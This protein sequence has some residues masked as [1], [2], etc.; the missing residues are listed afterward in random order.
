[1]KKTH[2][3]IVA[4]LF[5]ALAI[6]GCA[7]APEHSSLQHDNLPGL[8]PIRD[9]FI[10]IDSQLGYRLSPDG[11]KIGWMAVKK[12]RVTIFF[13]TIGESDVKVINTHSP[14]SI[15]G[16]HWAQDSQRMLYHQDRE[17]NENSHVYLVDT[18]HPERKPV[19]LTPFDETKAR[20][21]KILRTDP[22]NVL[23]E[24]NQ[25]DK[26]VYD[27]YCVNLNTLELTQ[28]AKNPG[29]VFSWITDDNGNLRARMRKTAQED[30]I[31]EVLNPSEKS[32]EKIIM[33]AMEDW[34]NYLSFTKDNKSMWL[35]SNRNRDRMGLVH[36]DLES[37]K[38]IL[39]YE[40]P[41]VDLGPVIISYLTKKPI[42]AISYPDYPKFHFFD[43]ESKKDFMIF[44]KSGPVGLRLMSTDNSERLVTLSV[45]TDKTVEYY[46]FKRDTKEKALLSRHP[47]SSYEEALSTVQPISFNSRDG[48]TIH[49]YLTIPKGSS[50]QNL[51][52][53]VLVHGGPWYRDYWGYK[54]RVQFLANRGYAV[55]Q[56]NYRGSTGYGRVFREAAVGEFAGKMHTDLIDGVQWAIR[57]GIADPQKIGVYGHSYGGYATLV[58]L[59]FTPET[60]ACGVDAVGPS[61]LV[62]LLE[63]VPKYWKHWM[64]YWY[65]YVGTPKNPEDRREM[66]EKSP[67]FRVSG[68]KRPL[69]I[70]QGGNDPRVK[71]KES[72][73][74]VSAMR[75][76][77]KEVEYLLFSDEGHSFTHWKN[78]LVFYRKVEDFLAKHLGGR[79]AGFDLYELAL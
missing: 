18:R 22:E 32:W 40:D 47:I 30:R 13:K 4:L 31:L 60:F 34:V 61:N 15:F 54:D 51:P 45:Y 55:L 41:K 49:G 62:T 59:T 39:I 6:V 3:I 48:L 36:F 1:M 23:I 67:L 70:A 7:T 56:I 9:L 72:D 76:A 77:G 79:S 33:W 57:K 73:Q 10:N 12:R 16:F 2:S 37:G 25:R 28:I 69:L 24:H 38:E 78:R 27:L 64:G 50:G 46:L 19:D 14:R 63:S 53:V 75:E 68:I 5:I 35:L 21:H 26:A 58:G 11:K 42:V 66:E 20:I 74:I 29:G 65:K 44:R 43:E 17:G 52:M 8:I 71:K